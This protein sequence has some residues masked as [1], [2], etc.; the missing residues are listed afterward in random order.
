MPPVSSETPVADI[1]AQSLGYPPSAPKVLPLLKRQLSDMDISIHQITE[2]IRLDPGISARVLQAANCALFSRGERC[3]SVA[4]AVHRIGFDQI[5][6]MVATAVA[7][8]VL[9]RPLAAYSLDADEFWRRSVACGLAAECV[10]EACGEDRNVAYTLG[11]LGGVG[12]VALDHWLQIHQPTIGFF[13][14]GYPRDYSDSERALL[15]CTNADVGCAVLRGWEFPAEMTEPVKWQY[16]PLDTFAH[17]GL[18]CTLHA[19]KWLGA[20]A[21]AANGARIGRID[22]RMLA[23]LRMTETSLERLL[24]AVAARLDQVQRKLDD[25]SP[26]EAA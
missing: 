1:I 12:M 24:P 6:E 23:P 3:H 20:R 8:Q 9:V 11:L 13:N 4:A 15:G 25:P 22:G 17:R 7:E 10:A 21:C 19:A 2:L 18:N 5:Y 16:A 14:R 26:G